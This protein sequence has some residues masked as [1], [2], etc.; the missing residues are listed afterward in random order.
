MSEEV[1]VKARE[2]EIGNHKYT[3]MQGSESDEKWVHIDNFKTQKNSVLIR[4]NDLFR[5]LDGVAMMEHKQT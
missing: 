2:L 4:K 3:E 5:F 1:L